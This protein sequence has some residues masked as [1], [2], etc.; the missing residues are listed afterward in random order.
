MQILVGSTTE[1]AATFFAYREK[2]FSDQ[3]LANEETEDQFST[4]N[5]HREALDDT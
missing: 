4:S 3:I 1:T 2:E 5:D